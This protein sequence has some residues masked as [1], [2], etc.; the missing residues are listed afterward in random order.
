[1]DSDD[2]DG[3]IKLNPVESDVEDQKQKSTQMPPILE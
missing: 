3:K 1:M 2:D